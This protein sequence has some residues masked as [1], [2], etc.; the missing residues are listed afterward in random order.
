MRLDVCGQLMVTLSRAPA[1]AC[2][3][4][5]ADEC[6]L[7]SSLG[8]LALASLTRSYALALHHVKLTARARAG[9]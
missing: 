6:H 5:C 8:R 7:W 2:R 9:F 1:W 4:R 3:F